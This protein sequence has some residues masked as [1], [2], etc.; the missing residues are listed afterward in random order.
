[1]KKLS[2]VLAILG[3]ILFS[4][5]LAI[6]QSADSL[7]GEPLHQYLKQKMIE[8]GAGYMGLLLFLLI[9]G[10]GIVIERVIYLSLASVNSKKLLDKVDEA[11]SSGG[12]EAA[13]EI[14]RNTR[15]P[16]ASIFYQGLLR[17]DQG[18]EA[19]EK[20]IVAYG[21]VQMNQL[22]KGLSWIQLFIAVLPMIGFLGTVIGMVMTFDDIAIAGDISPAVVSSGMKFALLT[23]VA[24]LVGAIPLQFCYNYLLAKLDTIVLDM[25]DSSISFVDLMVKHKK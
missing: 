2:K 24:A 13:K 17:S 21:G 1:M 6:A 15:G 25:E 18:L 23:T 20:S 7:D 22:E 10:L 8:G 5:Q 12:V 11:L 4:A 19:V 9:I 16:I 14:C 3:F